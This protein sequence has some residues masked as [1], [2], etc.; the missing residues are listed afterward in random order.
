MKKTLKKITIKAKHIPIMNN[1]IFK[2]I[3]GKKN[4]FAQKR[5]KRNSKE[6]K[7]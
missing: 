2:I 7:E 6:K 3:L 1:T 5:I 4:R